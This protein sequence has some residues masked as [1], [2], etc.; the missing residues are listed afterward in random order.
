MIVAQAAGEAQGR[1]R[2]PARLGRG[3]Q[4]AHVEPRVVGDEYVVGDDVEQRIRLIGRG[5][6]VDDIGG[7]DAVEGL[8]LRRGPLFLCPATARDVDEPWVTGG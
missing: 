1:H 4:H 6:S 5:E 7:G 3:A 8:V 2:N